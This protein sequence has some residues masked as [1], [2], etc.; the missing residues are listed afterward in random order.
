MPV[1]TNSDAPS[2]ADGDLVHTT[3]TAQGSSR[4][5]V[6]LTYRGDPKTLDVVV[7]QWVAAWSEWGVNPVLANQENAL[8]ACGAAAYLRDVLIPAVNAKLAE[9]FGGDVA[10]PPAVDSG[11]VPAWIAELDKLVCALKATDSGGTKVYQ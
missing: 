9:I 6:K 7:L 4:W 5:G 10:L 2:M 3:T 8:K 1:Q 11:D